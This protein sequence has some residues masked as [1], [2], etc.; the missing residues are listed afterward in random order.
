M[1]GPFDLSGK[2]A[3]VTGGNAGIG[4]GIAH[5]LAEAGAAVAVWGRR[6]E[7]NERAAREL[8]GPGRALAVACDVADEASVER[9]MEA[10]LSAF[11]RLDACFASAGVASERHPVERFPTEEWRRVLAIDLDGMFHTLR[12]AARELIAGGR[13]GSLVAL[14]SVS[15]LHGHPRH[16]PYA[17][18]K[19][20]IPGMTRSLA[21]E[22]ARHGIRANALLPGWIETELIADMTTDEKVRDAVIARIPMRRW[23]E[24][25]D[26]GGIAV[27]LASDASR[28][29]TG[30]A[31]RIDGGYAIH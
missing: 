23:G 24:P 26:L 7:A 13:G 1:S 11:G 14:S 12:A 31:F 28:Y 30:D 19:T 29:H 21:V 16:L 2:V 6:P 10:T 15:A 18:A 8:R 9:A 5:A 4:L 20:A 27:Y 25:A 17:A 3:V 22:L